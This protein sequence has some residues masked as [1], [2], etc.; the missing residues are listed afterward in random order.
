MAPAITLKELLA[1]NEESANFWKAHFDANPA[2]LELPCSIDNSG[3]VQEL[4][5][6]IWMA[7]LRWAQC[8]AGLPMVPRADLPKG[9][10]STLFEMHEQF[11]KVLR[12]LLS[13]PAHDW[14]D[15]IALPYEWIPPELRK[16]SGRKL[17]GHV[18]FHSQRHW[19]QLAT[20]LRTAGFP[21]G[22]LGDLIFTSAMA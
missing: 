17:A 4:V 6:H 3:H 12:T 10:L 22:F 20:H 13:D 5:R 2:L 11:A 16:A 14:D 1:W 8:I 9:P 15:T 7:E 19:A 18:L 21:S